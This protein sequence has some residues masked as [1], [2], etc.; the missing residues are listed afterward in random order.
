M[1]CDKNWEYCQHLTDPS[2]CCERATHANKPPLEV[3]A[4]NLLDGLQPTCDGPQPIL[5]MASNLLGSPM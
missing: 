3:T 4:S 2:N 5:A 1:A